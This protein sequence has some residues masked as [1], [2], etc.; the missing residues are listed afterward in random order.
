MSDPTDQPWVPYPQRELRRATA[1]R[2]AAGDE[3]WT[4]WPDLATRNKLAACIR[5]WLWDDMHGG[6]VET[7]LSA[8]TQE[9]SD[10]AGVVSRAAETPELFG[11]Q[12]VDDFVD[13]I[14]Q[15]D[16]YPAV[17]FGLI[18]GLWRWRTVI[19]EE[20]IARSPRSRQLFQ[21]R[22]AE[23][24]E[25]HRIGFVFVDGNF[26]PRSGSIADREILVPTVEFLTGDP[27]FAD[28]DAMYREALTAIQQRQP[29]EAITKA[30][31][32]LQSMLTALNCG[33]GSDT[34]SR[35]VAHAI[36]RGLLAK[37]DKPLEGWLTA[38]RGNFGSAHPGDGTAA[39]EDA[40]LT[41]HVVG[42]IILRLS[43]GSARGA[44]AE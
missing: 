4:E 39:R 15:P 36:G 8:I 42:A 31:T 25:D 11:R 13:S 21:D 3:L 32:A 27:T 41:V 18:E 10:A 33:D 1:E 44:S 6:G 43:R 38:D 24:L 20:F 7:L 2:E 37:H 22:I 28:A 12:S 34:L 19:D 35:Q 40:W 5:D 23:I 14:R 16:Q 30:C 29:D 9:V 17:I 26:L